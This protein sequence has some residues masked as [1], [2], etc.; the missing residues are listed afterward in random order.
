M[1]SSHVV[2]V[3]MYVPVCVFVYMCMF[4]ICM[5]VY[6]C[7]IL[8]GKQGDSSYMCVYMCVH[9]HRRIRS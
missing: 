9:V 1:V 8:V 6:M 5:S 3:H 7:D 4:L 2:C